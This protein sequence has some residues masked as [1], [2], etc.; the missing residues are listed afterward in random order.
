MHRMG[1]GIWGPIAIRSSARR[2]SCRREAGGWGLSSQR[3]FTWV[4]GAIAIGDEGTGCRTERDEVSSGLG[5]VVAEHSQ[6]HSAHGLPARGDVEI[7]L[8]GHLYLLGRALHQLRRGPGGPHPPALSL[9][10]LLAP[11]K[12]SIGGKAPEPWGGGC[13]AHLSAKARFAAAAAAPSDITSR[14][15]TLLC[16]G[17]ASAEEA[18]TRKVRVWVAVVPP[19]QSTHTCMPIKRGCAFVE[20][21]PSPLLSALSTPA[22]TRHPADRGGAR[23]TYAVRQRRFARGAPPA[24]GGPRERLRR[25]W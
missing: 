23:W 7:H 21:I 13:C 18:C 24:G 14:L 12:H 3:A 8:G 19:A 2:R 11:S 17:F 20:T 9:C 16:T 10:L 5:R 22:P 1:A 6:R 25:R 4:V 15:V